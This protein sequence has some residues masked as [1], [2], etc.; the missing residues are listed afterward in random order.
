VYTDNLPRNAVDFTGFSETKINPDKNIHEQ[1]EKELKRLLYSRHN[2]GR[3][4]YKD[5]D[6]GS[7]NDED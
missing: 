6:T 7:G 4:F 3:Q 2:S 1:L 5:E